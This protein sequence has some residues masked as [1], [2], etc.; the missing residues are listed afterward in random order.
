MNVKFRSSRVILVWSIE[1]LEDGG[2]RV[3][4]ASTTR[5]RRRRVG[6][7]DISRQGNRLVY[8]VCA[9][10]YESLAGRSPGRSEP[11]EAVKFIASTRD[12]MEPAYSPD[13]RKIAF[14]SKRSGSAEI[15]ICDSDSS[16][17]VQLTSF[18]GPANQ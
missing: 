18:G 5:L 8:S 12:D 7:P 17:P 11:K 9:R 6:S 10:R 13:G 16:H 4:S 14:M 2:V 15:W 1:P 3:C